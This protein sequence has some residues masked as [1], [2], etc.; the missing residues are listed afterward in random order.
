MKLRAVV[1]VLALAMAPVGLTAQVA[2][3][4]PT[5][6]LQVKP[7][8]TRRASS[9]DRVEHTLRRADALTAMAHR[10]PQAA[11]DAALAKRATDLAAQSR[12]A[13]A[14]A[15][16]EFEA[17]EYAKADRS[18]R[19][20]MSLAERAIAVSLGAA[21]GEETV[22]T[23]EVVTVAAPTSMPAAPPA[24]RIHPRGLPKVVGP[25][26]FGADPVSGA[27]PPLGNAMP[28]GTEAPEPLVQPL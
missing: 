26:P 17:R 4:P 6:G 5:P 15:T 9:R 1:P 12:T 8:S 28:F 20:A 14:A 22:E 7:S 27:V 3:P 18:A 13:Y 10:A 19:T 21:A 25:I 2:S 24:P 23:G 16:T 11:P